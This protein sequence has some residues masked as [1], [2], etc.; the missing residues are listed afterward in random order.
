MKAQQVKTALKKLSTPERAK[1]SAWFFKT[2]PGEY[3]EGDKFIGVTVPDQRKVAKQFRDLPESEILELLKSPIHEHRLTA[4][5]ILVDQYKRAESKRK[6]Q[7]SDLYLKHRKHVN[8]WDLVDSSA[9][10]LLDQASPDLLRKLAKS[11]SLW[12]R[13]IAII[14]TFA[15]ISKHEFALT[16]QI[17]EML[18]KDKED[19]IHKAVGWALREVGKKDQETLLK[20]LNTH[21]AAMPRTALR[22]AIERLTPAQRAHYLKQKLLANIQ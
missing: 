15:R 13:R 8:N 7:I 12:D 10:Y 21:A 14:A 11:K 2:K 19:L 4:L 1:A 20:F 16:L 9:P 5:F 17:A 22:Y 3:G 18:L 6:T